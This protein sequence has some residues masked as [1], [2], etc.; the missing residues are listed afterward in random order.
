MRARRGH[1][2]GRLKGSEQQGLR[3][4]IDN[5]DQKK[6]KYNDNNQI[7]RY[8]M[9]LGPRPPAVSSVVLPAPLAPRA[10]ALTMRVLYLKSIKHVCIATMNR[11]RRRS[12]ALCALALALF[13]SHKG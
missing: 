12:G 7:P 10:I 3:K 6:T 4:Y 5:P 8:S 1:I 9:P 11:A 13:A 2:S